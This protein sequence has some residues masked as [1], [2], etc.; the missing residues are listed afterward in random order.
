MTFF[1]K[2]PVLFHLNTT[3][4]LVLVGVQHFREEC[5]SGACCVWRQWS[6]ERLCVVTRSE[7]ESETDG[8]YVSCC[9]LPCKR[10]QV[11]SRSQSVTSPSLE[12]HPDKRTGNNIGCFN[13]VT[14]AFI[15]VSNVGGQEDLI[16]VLWLSFLRRQT[17]NNRLF[18]PNMKVWII[19]LAQYYLYFKCNCNIQYF[20][21]IK[22]SHR[23][24]LSLIPWVPEVFFSV[25]R[26]YGSWFECPTT[27]RH[28]QH[29]V[30]SLKGQVCIWSK[31]PIRPGFI[32]VPVPLNN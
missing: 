11:S 26:I 28:L 21:S 1:T 14:L 15:L 18:S 12:E 3:F 8:E 25:G 30:K 23:G 5:W 32:S 7:M 20:P 27:E 16:E 9:Y 31:C 29:E 13:T 2:I 4:T 19:I 17:I 10:N 6:C 24:V 22:W